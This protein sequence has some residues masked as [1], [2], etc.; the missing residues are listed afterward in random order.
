MNQEAEAERER[1]RPVDVTPKD[2]AL[3]EGQNRDFNYPPQQPL[4]LNEGKFRNRNQKGRFAPGM[5]EGNYVPKQ[6]GVEIPTPAPLEN[7]ATKSLKDLQIIAVKIHDDMGKYHDE[8][9]T[10]TDATL[11]QEEEKRIATKEQQDELIKTI[12]LLGTGP[13]TNNKEKDLNKKGIWDTIKDMLPGAGAG[14]GAAAGAGA[15]AGAG[16]AGAGAAGVAG[17]AGTLGAGGAALGLAGAAGTVIASGWVANKMADK[18]LD[19]M[20]VDQPPFDLYAE[21]LTDNGVKGMEKHWWIPDVVWKTKV[22][23]NFKGLSKAYGGTSWYDEWLKSKHPDEAKKLHAAESPKEKTSEQTPAPGPTPKEKEPPSP[24]MAGPG[25]GNAAFVAPSKMGTTGQPNVYQSSSQT[26]TMVS[27]S[28]ANAPVSSP[29]PSMT[30]S[31]APQPSAPVLTTG[32]VQPGQMKMSTKG[33]EGIKKHEGFAA[34]P[35][36]DGFGHQS[37][38]YGHQIQ[39]GEKFT[40]I[41]KATATTLLKGDMTKYEK[42]VNNSVKI[43]LTQDMADSMIDLAYNLPAAVPKVAAKLNKR[44]YTGAISTMKSYN[45]WHNPK[46]NKVEVLSSL[47]DRRTEEAAAFSSSQ[48]ALLPPA[49]PSQGKAIL[50]TTKDNEDKKAEQSQ[51]KGGGNVVVAPSNTTNNSAAVISQQQDPHNRDNTYRDTRRNNSFSS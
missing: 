29:P 30:P 31:T 16:A 2:R 36:P 42:I 14:A 3:R 25:A 49:P 51:N 45:K 33:I 7:D 11:A 46:T 8:E 37:I 44:D 28:S 17:A 19:V 5:M 40:E 48:V 38:G 47:N 13:T 6:K 23:N 24:K 41:D 9:T 27:G 21:A 12:K 20:G 4:F 50:A 15:G 35:Y 43:P 22:W 26:P 34:K 1:N 10:K 39:K 18:A 32:L